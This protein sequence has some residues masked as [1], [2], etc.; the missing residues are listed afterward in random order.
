MNLRKRRRL[1][2]TP[3]YHTSSK[4]MSRPS[5]DMSFEDAETRSRVVWTA[6]EERI[7]LSQL[8][9][10]ENTKPTPQMWNQVASSMEKPSKGAPKTGESC[11]TKWNRVSHFILF[12]F[13]L[14]DYSAIQLKENF[15]TIKHIT[16]QSG[17]PRWTPDKGLNFREDEDKSVWK[18]YI[19]V[20]VSPFFYIFTT[21][22]VLYR[23]TPRLK[24]W[25]KKDGHYMGMSKS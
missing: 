5:K 14:V 11:K 23:N 7:L 3:S 8:Q 13:T 16:K 10:L 9:K 20:S 19:K 17:F 25:E 15:K 18:E 2:H 1:Y 4:V 22:P 24:H 21:Y 12:R 6:D